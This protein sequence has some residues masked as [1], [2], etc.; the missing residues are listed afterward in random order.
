MST[1]HSH[2]STQTLL[3]V[4]PTGLPV[5]TSYSSRGDSGVCGWESLGGAVPQGSGWSSRKDRCA[6]DY[7][8]RGRVAHLG[9][10]RLTDS[11]MLGGCRW[12]LHLGLPCPFPTHCPWTQLCPPLTSGTLTEQ[13]VKC[14]TVLMGGC[15]TSRSCFP[16]ARLSLDPVWGQLSIR[17]M[18]WNMGAFPGFETLMS[19]ILNHGRWLLH[20]NFPGEASGLSWTR[21]QS[22]ASDGLRRPPS[23]QLLASTIVLK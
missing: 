13:A 23:P 4:A 6:G 9:D 19:P 21:L 16:G 22:L 18:D 15:M 12:H 5:A 8:S 17:L 7:C 20:H 11:F 10:H 14:T 1:S 2:V 3:G